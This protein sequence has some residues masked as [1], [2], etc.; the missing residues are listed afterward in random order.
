[1]HTKTANCY[2]QQGSS[3]T[4]YT[5]LHKQKVYQ[6]I[7]FTSYFIK[8]I[9]GLNWLVISKNIQLKKKGFLRYGRPKGSSITV[10][11]LHQKC[12]ELLDF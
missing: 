2:T 9:S 7:A 12:L 3:T 5:F 8:Q 10:T 4:E 11:L 6:Q 1:M